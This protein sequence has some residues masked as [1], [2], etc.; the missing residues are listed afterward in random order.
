MDEIT[1]DTPVTLADKFDELQDQF[2]Y[3]CKIIR[4]LTIEVKRLKGTDGK[5]AV[6][7][8]SGVTISCGTCKC[9]NEH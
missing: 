2:E 1:A 8:V 6:S 3:A 5:N 7:G 4:A 9:G